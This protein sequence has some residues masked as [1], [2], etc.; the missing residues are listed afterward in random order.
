MDNHDAFDSEENYA[1]EFA[2]TEN[3]GETC[4]ATCPRNTT[5]WIVRAITKV[6]KKAIK[7]LGTSTFFSVPGRIQ[8]FWIF[9]KREH[10]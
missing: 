8:D 1:F 9:V 4:N 3:Q 6:L 2:V 10:L 7:C 5:T